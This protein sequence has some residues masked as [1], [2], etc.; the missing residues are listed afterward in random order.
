MFAKSSIQ[1]R[2]LASLTGKSSLA[3]RATEDHSTWPK[4]GAGGLCASLL[5]AGLSRTLLQADAQ[6]QEV[7]LHTLRSWR[8]SMPNLALKHSM[9]RALSQMSCSIKVSLS[10]LL[11]C[12]ETADRARRLRQLHDAKN[13]GFPTRRMEE[14]ELCW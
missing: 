1:L 3:S 12:Q 2:R 5:A 6:R 4:T 9:T 8:S 13:K 14:P 10:Y 11:C 7:I